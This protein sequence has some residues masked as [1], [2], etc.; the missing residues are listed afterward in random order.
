MLQNLCREIQALASLTNAVS[1]N[2]V[3]DSFNTY[4]ESEFMTDVSAF[5][6]REIVSYDTVHKDSDCLITDSTKVRN[7]S[8]IKAPIS[9]LVYPLDRYTD[10]RVFSV[11]TN[12]VAPNRF[13][14]YSFL[15]TQRESEFFTS[16]NISL[17]GRGE[18]SVTSSFVLKGDDLTNLSNYWTKADVYN[19]NNDRVAS[20]VITHGITAKSA[21]NRGF[22]MSIDYKNRSL[23]VYIDGN[24]NTSEVYTVEIKSFISSANTLIKENV[25]YAPI[26]QRDFNNDIFLECYVSPTLLYGIDDKLDDRL[27]DF[28]RIISL[29]VAKNLAIKFR[30]SA[31]SDQLIARYNMELGTYTDKERQKDILRYKNRF[32][33]SDPLQ[34]MPG[35][36]WSAYDAGAIGYGNW[37]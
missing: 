25:L 10:R 15:S 8:D 21:T 28:R 35:Y 7:V 17:I 9:S 36:G 5:I 37:R 6:N 13:Y 2:D 32:V 19:S 33:E 16:G 14:G 20:L 31:V 12:A 34:G 3:I 29:G 18:L 27:L 11:N 4:L 23:A 26:S 30:D 22:I 24:N 1:V